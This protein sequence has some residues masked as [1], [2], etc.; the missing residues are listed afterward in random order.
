MNKT[1][2]IYGERCDELFYKKDHANRTST[3]K[4]LLERGGRS[5][6]VN[7]KFKIN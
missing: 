6:N 7:N 2:A 4:K 3:R 5:L 1:Y